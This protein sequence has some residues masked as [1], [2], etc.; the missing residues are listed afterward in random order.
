MLHQVVIRL[1]YVGSLQRAGK[2][3]TLQAFFCWSCS[4]F[5]FCSQPTGLTDN[6]KNTVALYDTRHI[7][8]CLGLQLA[9]SG[10]D[11]LLYD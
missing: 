11:L 8:P 1:M 10:A 4:R 7:M 6:A 9:V 2:N 3:Y 5:T